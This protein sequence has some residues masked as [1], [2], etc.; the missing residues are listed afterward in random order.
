MLIG[1]GIPQAHVCM[2][3]DM[4]KLGPTVIDPI[5]ELPLESTM[6]DYE[7]QVPGCIK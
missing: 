2:D 1:C 5:L 6:V 3:V 7:G 4:P